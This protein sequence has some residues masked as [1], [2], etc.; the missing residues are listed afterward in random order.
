VRHS[1]YR[2]GELANGDLKEKVLQDRV[3]E[4][5]RMSIFEFYSESR[6]ELGV[7]C[8]GCKVYKTSAYGLEVGKKDK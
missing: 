6:K 3:T 1:A 4:V 8:R 7:L 5:I 2:R